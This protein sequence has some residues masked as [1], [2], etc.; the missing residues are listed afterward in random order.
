[1]KIL[2]ISIL[3]QPD[4]SIGAVR[5][6]NFAQWLAEFGH[7][8]DVITTNQESP[9]LN[10]NNLRIYFVANSKIVSRFLHN[11]LNKIAANKNTSALKNNIKNNKLK[12]RSP[13]KGI[14]T[15]ILNLLQ[16]YDWKNQ[17]LKSFSEKA[18]EGEYDI[19]FSSYGP[20]GSYW[21]GRSL[22]K[23]KIAKYWVSDLRDLMVMGA[24]PSW[25]KKFY[26]YFQKQTLREATA[27]TVVSFGAD[28][29]LS[30]QYCNNDKHKKKINVIHNGYEVNPI[31][32]SL[33]KSDY[34]LRICYTGALYSGQRDMSLL[35]ETISELINDGKIETEK[36]EVHYAGRES[37]ELLS[38][39]APYSLNCIVDHGF[40]PREDALALQYS[41]DILLVLSWNTQKDQ[42]ILP[43]K[44][45]EYLAARKPIISIIS[46]DLPNAELSSM[47]RDISLGI[48]CEYASKQNDI[49]LLKKYIL[50]CYQCR[51]NGEKIPLDPN[52]EMV[53]E[54]RYDNL[55]RKLEEL[56]NK[57]QGE[58][59]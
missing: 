18:Q 56:F 44:F 7:E 12:S 51:I 27:I 57:I 29:I 40:I 8:V 54:Y 37:A 36:I 48:A 5:P 59:H 23:R 43:G 41:S 49:E 35:F 20:I 45:Y 17:C 3:F 19:V 22:Y 4:N 25:L 15:L 38:Q 46:G 33:E 13:L 1:M 10:K 2:I 28:K 24:L 58:M 47:V 14:R 26:T 34:V 6:T 16:S 50:K 11:T 39:A 9:K 31:S 30:D 21:L 42:G 55:T 32:F 53:E 52:K